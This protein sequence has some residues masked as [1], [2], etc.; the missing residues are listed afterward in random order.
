M[1]VLKRF[2]GL[3]LFLL[4]S[5]TAFSQTRSLNEQVFDSLNC[6]VPYAN[7]VA[8]NQSTQKIGAFA[9]TNA[10]GKFRLA[11]VPGQNFLLRVSFVG[12]KQFEKEITDWSDDDLLKIIL[13]QDETSLDMVEV[14]TELPVT[15]NGNTLT[16]KTDAFTTGTERK[17]KDVLEKLPGFEVNDNGEVK[18][19]GKK[20]R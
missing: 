1:Q 17:L 6:A 18:V 7:V 8:I 19:Q 14:V 12:F 13:M 2:L 4:I 9:I 15:M 5:A 20:S 10:E 11:L 16:Y 3:S